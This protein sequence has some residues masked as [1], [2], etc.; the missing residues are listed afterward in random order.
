MIGLEILGALDKFR[1]VFDIDRYR[2][3]DRNDAF[4]Y[5]LAHRHEAAMEEIW[6]QSK[7]K[8]IHIPSRAYLIWARKRVAEAAVRLRNR[9]CHRL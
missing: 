6:E 8:G 7:A 2:T 5:L 3:K 9:I 1:G 4:A